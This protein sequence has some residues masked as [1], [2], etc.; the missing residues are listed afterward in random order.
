MCE[1]CLAF[2]TQG[3][4]PSKLESLPCARSSCSPPTERLPRR[5]RRGWDLANHNLADSVPV[6]KKFY[7]YR[8]AVSILDEWFR[9]HPEEQDLRDKLMI[10]GFLRHSKQRSALPSHGCWLASQT[11]TLKPSSELDGEG[12]SELKTIASGHDYVR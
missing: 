7:P 2:R 12:Q 4:S 11:C 8:D 9:A 5:F 10:Q 6:E 3:T 1:V